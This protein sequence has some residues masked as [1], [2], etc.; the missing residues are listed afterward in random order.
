MVALHKKRKQTWYFLFC[1][2]TIHTNQLQESNFEKDSEKKNLFSINSILDPIN[3]KEP[4]SKLYVDNKLNHPS[5]IKN[6]AHVDFNDE[7][8]PNV[9]FM[10]LNSNPAKREHARIKYYVDQSIDE[11][12]PVRNFKI[13]FKINDFNNRF[14]SNI[15]QITLNSER[16]DNIHIATKSYVDLLSENDRN[17]HDLSTVY[18]DQ[19]NGFE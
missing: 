17:R 4:A 1:T 10:K 9:H 13:I 18:N 2:K 6:T 16:I 19:N 8:L 3:I 14:S 5:I 7:N 15:L 11:P 12:A